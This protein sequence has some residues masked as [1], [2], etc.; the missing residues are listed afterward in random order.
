M[1]NEQEV[2]VR[3]KTEAKKKKISINKLLANCNMGKNT[4]AKMANGT[5]IL[6]QNFGKIAENLDCSADYLLGRTDTS[7]LVNLPDE[8]VR[9]IMD[10]YNEKKYDFIDEKELDEIVKPP[11]IGRNYYLI[12]F[13]MYGK[14]IE[15]YDKASTFDSNKL[16][17]II[18]SKEAFEAL[19][20]Y[21]KGIGAGKN[22]EGIYPT[23]ELSKSDYN[24]FKQVYKLYKRSFI[25]TAFRSKN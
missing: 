20:K 19:F 17:T 21:K 15:I 4:I 6:T 9:E 1:Y 13:K 18:E 2:A 11:N 16:K 14:V 8:L 5:D 10:E 3:I 23:Y 7:I 22:T 24:I 25:S 12:E